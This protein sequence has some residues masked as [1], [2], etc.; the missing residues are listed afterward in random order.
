MKLSKNQIPKDIC[1]PGQFFSE[2]LENVGKG[3]IEV[4]RVSLIDFINKKILENKIIVDSNSG[5]STIFNALT[6]D[7]ETGSTGGVSTIGINKV[8]NSKAAQMPFYTIKGNN[9]GTTANPQDL[10]TSEV[11][12]LLAIVDNEIVTSQTLVINGTIRPAG[13]SVYIILS[14]LSSS[15]IKDSIPTISST[16]AVQSGGVFTALSMKTDKTT[17]TAKGSLYTATSANT[18]VELPVG[19]NGQVLT[20][21]STQAKGIKWATVNSG[22]STKAR[23][24]LAGTGIATGTKLDV[25]YEILTGTPI[26][27]YIISSGTGTLTVS[28]GTID[29]K[30]IQANIDTLSDTADGLFK[31]VISVLNNSTMLEYP[32]VSLIYTVNNQAPSTVSPHI[33]RDIQSAPALTITESTLGSSISVKTGD[34]TAA[35]TTASL[36]CLF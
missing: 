2:E 30:R 7:V 25:K 10:T 18:I 36:I 1:L 8:T 28:N 16:N 21:D 26:L 11:K 12:T 29:V 20:A 9:T 5:G 19:S 35:G 14:D 24:Q 13:T 33:Y 32:V 22:S 4:Q 31:L 17:L 6:G 15:T 27:S 23:V 34:L 3:S